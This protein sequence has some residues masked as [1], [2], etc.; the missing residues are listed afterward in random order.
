M[1]KCFNR[2]NKVG[3]NSTAEGSS[4]LRKAGRRAMRTDA[5]LLE[6]AATTVANPR[7][8]P[9]IQPFGVEHYFM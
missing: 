9:P 1:S 7:P 6:T 2:E 3:M 8:I 4:Y 5:S